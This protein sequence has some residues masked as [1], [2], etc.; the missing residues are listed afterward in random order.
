AKDI[1]DKVAKSGECDFVRT[2]AAELPLQVIA[3][4]L[5]VP[6]EERFRLFD[7]SN[8]LIGFDDPEFQTSHED[9]RQAAME[10]WMYS[11]E[12][13]EARKDQKGEDLVSV[14]INAEINGEKLT[15]MEFNGFFLL[16]AV[17]G[18]ETTRNLISGG[19][20][21]LMANPDQR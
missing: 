15:E 13:A 21:E 16:L 20:V 10:L 4:L 9:A 12:L 11:N 14:L 19:M 17:A 7:L 3:E 2:I 18:N 6:I 8:R 5:G 1:V